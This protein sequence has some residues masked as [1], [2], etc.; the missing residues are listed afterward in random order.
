M[1]LPTLLVVDDEK[2]TREA[3][4]KLLATEFDI[5]IAPA[6][7]EAQ[8][9]I[10]QQYFQAILT[11]LRLGGHQSGLDIVA[12]AIQKHIPC[13]VMTAFGDVDTAV[14]AMKNGAFDFVT[15]PINLQRLKITLRQAVANKNDSYSQNVNVL[16]ASFESRVIF[17]EH[18]PF[19][20]TME[21][22]TKI[23][24]SN[25]N[26]LLFGETG[27]GKEILAQTIHQSSKRRDHLLVTVH[28]ASL[29]STLL[30]SELFGHE[31]GAFTGATARHMG[32]F[33]VA[34]RGTLFLDEIGEIDGNIQVKLLR[35]LET[36]TFERV[37]GTE[38][39][40]VSLRIIAA[41]H[42][43][44]LQMVQRKTFR[45]DLYYRL[46]VIELKVPPLRERCDDIPLLFHHYIGIFCQ[47]NAIPVPKISPQIIEK[48][49]H[50]P[51]PGNIREL[52]NTCESIIALLP[53]NQDEITVNDLGE[54]FS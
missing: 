2:N 28:C 9:Y 52:R 13:I 14:D 16:P 45:E 3:L 1:T 4:K 44:L 12:L 54:K 43:N 48:L 50:Y 6:V 7:H 17:S 23:A 11:D 26:V 49:T 36:R 39:I 19:K 21:Y 10:Q 27:T 18:S 8:E 38:S 24:D 31:K 22:A 35:F 51:W 34:D 29:S 33:E 37:G 5:C 32:R 40:H 42:R 15:K 30:E 46:N 41:T 47:E 25:A 20:R 53:K